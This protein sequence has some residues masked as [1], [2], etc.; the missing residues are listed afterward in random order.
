MIPYITFEGDDIVIRGDHELRVAMSDVQ[1]YV[2][3]DTPAGIDAVG[4]ATPTVV[5]RRDEIDIYNQPENAVLEVYA[6]NG[7]LVK[8]VNL[9]NEKTAI[10]S[11]CPL[12]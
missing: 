6:V 12:M 10:I 5:F 2:Y 7:S 11:I 9:N 3:T 4:D 1:R 8:S